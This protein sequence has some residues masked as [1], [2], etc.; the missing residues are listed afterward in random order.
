M[1]RRILLADDSHTIRKVVELT[2]ADSDFEVVAVPN[3]EL[4]L[5]KIRERRPD[6]ILLDVI[7]PGKDGYDICE[8]VKADPN[9]S[10]IPVLLM[11]G[12]FEP[13]DRERAQ[14]AG[15]DGFLSKPFD[16]RGLVTRINELLNAATMAAAPPST[17]EPIMA[18]AAPDIAKP[19]TKTPQVSKPDETIIFPA[20]KEVRALDGIGFEDFASTSQP[21]ISADKLPPPRPP[22]EASFADLADDLKEW[23][24]SQSGHRKAPVLPPESATTMPAEPIFP[25]KVELPQKPASKAPPAPI[26]EPL[27]LWRIEP[28][29]LAIPGAPVLRPELARTHESLDTNPLPR[30]THAI[31]EAAVPELP[32]EAVVEEQPET[33]EQPLTE[34]VSPLG[35]PTILV[36]EPYRVEPELYIEG[37]PI[38]GE[39]PPQVVETSTEPFELISEVDEPAAAADLAPPLQDYGYIRENY[40][41]EFTLEEMTSTG[42]PAQIPV[43]DESS[44]TAVELQ[45]EEEQF[46]PAPHEAVATALQEILIS[47]EATAPEPDFIID[48]PLAPFSRVI[49]DEEVVVQKLDLTP[50][51]VT[52][53]NLDFTREAVMPGEA[54]EKAGEQPIEVPYI[55]EP[56]VIFSNTMP[57]RI[58]MIRSEISQAPPIVP[59][60]QIEPMAAPQKEEEFPWAEA[61]A[62]ITEEA[63][64]FEEPLEVAVP[65][66][67]EASVEPPQ[68][69]VSIEPP[70]EEAVVPPEILEISPVSE[71]IEAAPGDEQV[72]QIEDVAVPAVDEQPAPV[73]TEEEIAAPAP[74]EEL[75]LQ[76]E[77]LAVDEQSAEIS[78]PVEEAPI[79]EFA[80]SIAVKA[81][82]PVEAPSEF[83]GVPEDAEQPAMRPS[84]METLPDIFKAGPQMLRLDALPEEM[85][86][87]IA[88]R[89]VSMLSEKMI[90]QIAWEVVPDLAETLIKK[91]IERLQKGM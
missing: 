70:A 61:A 60:L 38:P 74:S 49:T 62:A 13:F 50:G 76:E 69:I 80:P 82:K 57:L 42:E 68:D 58:P 12:S 15:S 44:E 31:H 43:T 1:G 4:A 23:E 10:A 55:N 22:I 47:E 66:T 14:R 59:T 56:Q 24:R 30:L 71:S 83:A 3:G 18:E 19:V 8:F 91:E 54:R 73:V 67:A 9:L 34:E 25:L 29:P 35:E 77:P 48:E 86:N 26:I 75:H 46:V 7:M 78:L 51:P 41:R 64:S 20:F 79:E 5:Q 45:P 39:E 37:E 28:T 85:V 89:A 16:S 21:A 6:V 40:E 11:A 36:E 65:E 72:E 63:P 53:E 84:Y 52:D 90:E 88:R 87:A 17:P 2:F 32:G 27:P 81:A 33:E